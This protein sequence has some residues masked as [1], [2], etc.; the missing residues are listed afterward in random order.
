[1]IFKKKTLEK[2]QKT[3]LKQIKEHKICKPANQLSF[4]EI[5][6]DKEMCVWL[7]PKEQTCFNSG[8]FTEQDL[9]DWMEGKGNVVKGDTDEGKEKFW[10][11]A[12]FLEENDYG[13]IIALNFEHFN[14]VDDSYNVEY[15]NYGYLNSI[16]KN[17]LKITKSNK[18]TIIEKVFG[19]QIKYICDDLEYSQVD[20]GRQY[21]KYREIFYGI[22]S[23]LVI[24]GCGYYGCSN[25]PVD[26]ENLNWFT[27]V[28]FAKGY[29]KALIKRGIEMPDFNYVKENR[30]LL[31]K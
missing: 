17:P 18:K 13:W 1:M 25:T 29:Y 26:I 15:D 28:V 4:K 3:V 11:M 5:G 23:T 20:V 24:L 10:N 16:I 31:S 8:W 2:P 30:Y 14:L 19:N 12:V 7:N 22:K 9:L 21:E 6:K 27:D